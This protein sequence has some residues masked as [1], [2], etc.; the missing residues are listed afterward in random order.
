MREA[1][2]PDQRGPGGDDEQA[3]QSGG[4]VGH[5][6]AAQAGFGDVVVYDGDAGTGPR[7]SGGTAP[8]VLPPRER[9]PR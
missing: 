9:A 6:G 3:L 2:P 1:R 5:V 8:E 4:V 7:A